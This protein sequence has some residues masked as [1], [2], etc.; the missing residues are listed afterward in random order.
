MRNILMA[1]ALLLIVGVGY[2]YNSYNSLK[3]SVKEKEGIISS[4]EIEVDTLSEAYFNCVRQREALSE[5]LGETNRV[6]SSLTEDKNQIQKGI[7]D[8]LN[9]P[10]TKGRE[11]NGKDKGTSSY[12]LDPELIRMLDEAC[13]R[14]RGSECPNP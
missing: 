11:S 1:V 13:E 5:V 2:F 10:I 9:K 4:L 6:I 12:T 8:L 14:V 3:S 7:D